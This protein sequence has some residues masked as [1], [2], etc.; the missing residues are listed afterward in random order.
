MVLYPNSE[1]EDIARA[2][3]AAIL[4][5]DLPMFTITP[6]DLLLPDELMLYDTDDSGEMS[7]TSDTGTFFD[8]ISIGHFKSTYDLSRFKMLMC[9]HYTEQDRAGPI[10]QGLAETMVATLTN[11]PGEDKQKAQAAMVIVLI[12]STRPPY[13][14]RQYCAPDAAATEIVLM[15]RPAAERFAPLLE[16]KW[17]HFTELRA[18]WPGVL[19][20]HGIGDRVQ[21]LAAG[22]ALEGASSPTYATVT[23]PSPTCASPSS[24]TCRARCRP[25]PTRALQ[26]SSA[27]TARRATRTGCPTRKRR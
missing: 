19:T 26:R 2:I 21:A 7:A 20:E 25:R 6:H 11:D 4:S 9:N 24:R 23:P 5:A 3:N 17:Q 16:A 14:M 15:G 13:T 18:L 27:P 22:L 1:P 12:G 8:H 10:F